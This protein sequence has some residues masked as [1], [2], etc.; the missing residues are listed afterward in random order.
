VVLLAAVL[1]HRGEGKAVAFDQPPGLGSSRDEGTFSRSDF[2]VDAEH[3]RNATLA[4]R[5]QKKNL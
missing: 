4:A 3:N 1:P 5:A 2:T